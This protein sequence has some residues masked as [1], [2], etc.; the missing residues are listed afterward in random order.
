MPSGSEN[1]RGG[2][3]RGGGWEDEGRKQSDRKC[4]GGEGNH[5][6]RMSGVRCVRAVV[7]HVMPACSFTHVSLLG[8]ERKTQCES[9]ERQILK[10]FSSLTERDS[11]PQ[12]QSVIIFE[13]F[14]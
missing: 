13:Y 4:E 12:N 9:I 6:Q 5:G 2:A 10:I 8:K 1:G 14:L 7:Q 11:S 3:W